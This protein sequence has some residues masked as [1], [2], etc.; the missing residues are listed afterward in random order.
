M[1]PES[2]VEEPR[3]GRRLSFCVAVR[4]EMFIWTVRNAIRNTP[5]YITV[6]LVKHS[7][8]DQAIQFLLVALHPS[9]LYDSGF[10]YESLAAVCLLVPQPPG[11]ASARAFHHSSA[12]LWHDRILDTDAPRESSV[13]LQFPRGNSEA[14]RRRYSRST[15]VRK[16]MILLQTN[17]QKVSCSLMLRHQACVIHL[18]SSHH[19]DILTSHIMTRRR[20][21]STVQRP[22][23]H[24]FYYSILL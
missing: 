21:V 9:P 20:T 12:C 6:E 18:T 16:Q 14:S 1:S 13:L 5:S 3:D 24:N 22:H 19:I 11:E 7:R 10:I 4:L 17:Y 2:H 23:S 8:D 15:A